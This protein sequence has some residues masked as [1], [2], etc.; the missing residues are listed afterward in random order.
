MSNHDYL[1]QLKR[2]NLSEIAEVQL[3]VEAKLQ[4]IAALC[5]CNVYEVLNAMQRYQMSLSE[6]YN[7]TMEHRELPCCSK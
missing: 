5:I 6:M 7:Y 3:N 2:E 1:A 4:D